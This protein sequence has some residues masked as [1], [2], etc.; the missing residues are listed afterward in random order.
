[1]APEERSRLNMTDP[2]C[3]LFPK[4]AACHYSRYGMGGI[5]D[6]RHAICILGLNMVNDKIFALCWLWHCFIVIMGTVRIFTRSPQLGMIL[7]SCK[8]Q[9]FARQF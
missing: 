6:D 5:E 7:T 1:M 3:E 8:I 2:F 9:I 4:M